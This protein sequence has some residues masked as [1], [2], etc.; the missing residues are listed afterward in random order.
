MVSKDMLGVK[1]ED[2][3]KEILTEKEVARASKL[4]G[5][6]NDIRTY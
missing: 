4:Y 3:R 5:P 1:N 2:L 6:G